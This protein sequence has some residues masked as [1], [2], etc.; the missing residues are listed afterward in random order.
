MNGVKAWSL[1]TSCLWR[2]LYIHARRSL[3]ASCLWQHL[4][5]HARRI[6]WLLI[7]VMSSHS[8]GVAAAP[9]D[10]PRQ[11][12]A[13]AAAPATD[14]KKIRG[15]I[16]QLRSTLD[17]AR[18]RQ[19]TLRTKLST[20]EKDMGKTSRSLQQLQQQLQQH[21]QSLQ[22]LRQRQQQHQ[23]RLS[24]HRT[25]LA[26][27]LRASY[28]MGRQPQQDFVKVVFNQQD[29]ALFGRNL[30][31]YGYF[32][33]AHV[34]HIGQITSSLA[35]L[36]T[37]EQTT[38]AQTQQL[39]QVQSETERTR[40]QLETSRKERSTILV[41]LSSEIQSKEQHLQQL[42]EDERDLARLLKRLRDAQKRAKPT[43]P[44]SAKPTK[45]GQPAPAEE[46]RDIARPDPK[47]AFGRLQGQLDWPAQGALVARYGTSRKLGTSKWQGV[48]I[49]AP[50]GAEVRAVSRGKVVFAD[51]MRG[52]GLLMILDHGN[53]YMTLYGQNQTVNK[54]VGT[55]VDAGD[56]IA[57]VGNSGG[58]MSPGLYFEIRRDGVPVNPAAW[59]R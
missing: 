31:Y 58:Q 50:E 39:T 54:S 33:R 56:V 29:P 44:K 3:P 12:N 11:K 52:F 49:A 1:P 15:E 8:A 36:E 5:I 27:Q 51:W 47:S 13:K 4:C 46:P 16:R 59:C 7:V 28:A 57:S 48:L 6:T 18:D 9:A 24:T 41:A 37:L 34:A 32:N 45:P 25:A 2:H 38:Q 23:T 17:S 20:T 43:P 10:A 40:Q 53:G 42:L 22:Q 30:S 35:E 55:L 19:K 21:T 26:Q 14:L